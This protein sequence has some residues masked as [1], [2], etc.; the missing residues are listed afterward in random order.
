VKPQDAWDWR[1]VIVRQ[2]Q[3]QSYS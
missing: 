3:E 2:I 1:S